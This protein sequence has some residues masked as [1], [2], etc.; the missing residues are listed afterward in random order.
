MITSMRDNTTCEESN[1]MW[2]RIH[3]KYWFLNCKSQRA[4]E[5]F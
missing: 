1:K 4:I 2:G 3:W 5:I